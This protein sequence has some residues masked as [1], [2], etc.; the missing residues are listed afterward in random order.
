[1]ASSPS[2]ARPR[3]QTHTVPAGIS[4]RVQRSSKRAL[5]LFE[6]ATV[7]SAG[8]AGQAPSAGPGSNP[9]CTAIWKPLHG[10]I[11]GTRRSIAARSA[12]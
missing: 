12:G 3:V 6:S 10:Q 2:Q 11:M 7:A 9:A 5:A 4:M 1:M 8:C